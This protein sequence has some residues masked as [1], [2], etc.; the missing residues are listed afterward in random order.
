MQIHR[1]TRSL[2]NRTVPWAQESLAAYAMAAALHFNKQIPRCQQNR[3]NRKW[4]KFVM[5][6][7]D[8]KTIGFLYAQK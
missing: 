8:G 6:T 4:D 3:K 7:L 1:Q 2:T 5:D